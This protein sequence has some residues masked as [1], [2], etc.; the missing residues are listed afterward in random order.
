MLLAS[1]PTCVTREPSASQRPVVT[2]LIFASQ[3][4]I[5]T[6]EA[7]DVLERCRLHLVHNRK[8]CQHDLLLADVVKVIEQIKK[9][10]AS[11]VEDRK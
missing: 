3:T 9:G 2:H 8:R 11:N 5:V 4:M 6:Q 10:Q 1:H 7:M